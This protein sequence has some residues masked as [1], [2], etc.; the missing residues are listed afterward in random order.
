MSSAELV[1]GSQLALPG[2]FLCTEEPPAASFLEALKTTIEPPPPT[3]PLSYAQ[4]A[5][6]PA[7]GLLSAAFVYIRR[8]GSGPPLAP[9][10]TGPF[11]V[12]RREAKFFIVELG[13]RSEA[14]TVDRL[15]P[16]QGAAPVTAATP[17]ARGRPALSSAVPHPADPSPTADASAG[18]GS[19]SV[20]AE[21]PGNTR[22]GENPPI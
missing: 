1:Y 5:A 6:K 8:G 13:G 10:Y 9:L 20:S 7:A 18:G 19:C 16:H 21:N 17:P 15:K 2:E 22:P 12:L 11:R 14:V 4:V 3:A